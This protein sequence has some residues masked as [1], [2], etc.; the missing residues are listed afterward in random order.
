MQKI[1]KELMTNY[2]SFELDNKGHVF[3]TL[4]YSPDFLTSVIAL[5]NPLGTFSSK[6]ESA[7]GKL[8]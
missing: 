4:F 7:T 8:A 3:A 5:A 6:M 2:S 1:H